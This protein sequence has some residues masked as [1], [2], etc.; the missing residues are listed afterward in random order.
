[1]RFLQICATAKKQ[2]Y[3]SA[4]DTLQLLNGVC[5]PTDKLRVLNDTF[6]EVNKVSNSPFRQ[7]IFG[8]ACYRIDTLGRYIAFVSHKASSKEV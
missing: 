4:I 2:Y 8:S 1:M 7:N 3:K 6:A 5:T